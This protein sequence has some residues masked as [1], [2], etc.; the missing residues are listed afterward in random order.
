MAGFTPG[1][2]FFAHRSP[3]ACRNGMRELLDGDLLA[4]DEL[5][6]NLREIRLIN[7]G[8]GWTAATLHL[9]EQV[10]RATDLCMFSYL[11]VA[12]GS[13]DLPLAVLQRGRRLGWRVDAHAL[14]A[15]RQVLNVARRHI[16]EAPVTLHT[17]DACALP[18]T[19]RSFD[20]V[21]CA[22]ALHHFEPN[23]A[24]LVLRELERVARRAWIVVDIE[25]G[26]P[27]Y[28]GARLLRLVLRNRL[29]RHDAPA[30]VLR[31]YSL[32]ELRDLLTTAAV[33]WQVLAA[34]FPFRLVAYGVIA[35]ESGS[36]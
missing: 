29:T 11:D 36:K 30:S 34:Q 33:P 31:A 16:G 19:D 9:L 22:L 8:L 4:T 14:D 5:A 2:G 26:F 18:F 17:G 27:A 21:T 12:T 3:T 28:L 10:T 15:S 24:V 23:D 1:A 32:P 35:S 13:G 20:V 7:K 25:R 6:G